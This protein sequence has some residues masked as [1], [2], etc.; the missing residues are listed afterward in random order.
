MQLLLNCGF[1]AGCGS[2][3]PRPFV[4]RSNVPLH[5]AGVVVR[6]R[7]CTLPFS[8]IAVG[9]HPPLRNSLCLTTVMDKLEPVS[10]VVNH[11]HCNH[12]HRNPDCQGQ[13]LTNTAPPPER[14]L[15]P[16]CMQYGTLTGHVDTISVSIIC[17]SGLQTLADQ[18]SH[19]LSQHN[20]AGRLI[21]S[22]SPWN[23]S[24]YGKP[25]KEHRGT[26]SLSKPPHPHPLIAA[27][28]EERLLWLL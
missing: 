21:R 5:S 8:L 7:G 28:R 3:P 17:P 27:Q 24:T 22:H 23:I 14:P 10:R 16:H 15:G 4:P 2:C 18:I 13:A 19:N 20:S 11:L 12:R 1:V 26:T 6:S 25:L 9:V